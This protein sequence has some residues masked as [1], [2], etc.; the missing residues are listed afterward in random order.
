MAK[1]K[2]AEENQPLQPENVRKTAWLLRDRFT[3]KLIGKGKRLP[4]LVFVEGKDSYKRE[5]IHIIT[6]KPKNIS[7]L[8]FDEVFQKTASK[9]D[10]VHNE[11]D[12]REIEPQTQ[13]RVISYSLKEG[14]GALIPEASWTI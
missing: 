5:H 13:R 3:K 7:L 1:I 10:W 11:I 14:V 6:V 9:L 12:I 2:T 8:K 4:F